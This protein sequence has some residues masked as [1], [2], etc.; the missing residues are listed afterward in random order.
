MKS[1]SPPRGGWDA[2]RLVHRGTPGVRFGCGAAGRGGPRVVRFTSRAP[3][4]RLQWHPTST[5]RGRQ[6]ARRDRRMGAEIWVGRSFRWTSGCFSCWSMGR[7]LVGT[8][9]WVDRIYRCACGSAGGGSGLLGRVA[10]TRLKASS[11]TP[12]QR[13]A[14]VEQAQRTARDGGGRLRQPRV[15]RRRRHPEPVLVGRSVQS[16]PP[17]LVRR[18]RYTRLR[19]PPLFRR[20]AFESLVEINAPRIGATASARPRR[21][22]PTRRDATSSR[23]PPQCLGSPRCSSAAVQRTAER[24]QAV[25]RRRLRSLRRSALGVLMR[26][27][28]AESRRASTERC[29][30]G[31]SSNT[32][33][34]K[35]LLRRG[36]GCQPQR[37]TSCRR[38]A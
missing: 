12:T 22:R 15:P 10:R 25:R 37:F 29:R 13:F 6:D 11:S 8:W 36:R 4:Q 23:T 1:L 21:Y 20:T 38:T 9:S 30:S 16:L 2:R 7:H 24:P 19:G 35:V 27:S 34:E 28:R 32:I 33:P 31:C 3:K 14:T 5:V 18:R 26:S 17:N